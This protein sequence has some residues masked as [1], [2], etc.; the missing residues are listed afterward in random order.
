VVVCNL[1]EEDGQEITPEG[2]TFAFPIQPFEIR[3]F[4]LQL[5]KGVR[6]ERLAAS[7]SL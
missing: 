4:R 1:V 7:S 6:G 5:A 2:A 3:T